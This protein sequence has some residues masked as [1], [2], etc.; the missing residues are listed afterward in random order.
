[1]RLIWLKL[2]HCAVVQ[3][4]RDIFTQK[5]NVCEQVGGFA[6]FYARGSTVLLTLSGSRAILESSTLAIEVGVRHQGAR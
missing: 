3:T 6:P 1:M 5:L 4:I 2:G